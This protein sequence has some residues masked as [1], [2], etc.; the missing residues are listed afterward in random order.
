MEFQNFI[1]VCVCVRAHAVTQLCP[2]LWDPM[3]CSLPVSFC[4][5]IFQARVLEWIAISSSRASSLPREQTCISYIS[6]IGVQVP[7]H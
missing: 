5:G 2:T 7:Y 4:H 3:D 1:C 6:W